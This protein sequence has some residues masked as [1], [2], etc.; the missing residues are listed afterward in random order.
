MQKYLPFIDIIFYRHFGH[1]HCNASILVKHGLFDEKHKCIC[2]AISYTCGYPVGVDTD[3]K[4]LLY[5]DVYLHDFPHI[6]LQF[7]TSVDH[8]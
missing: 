6:F 3:K 7:T 1:V 5:E 4:H 2:I 8:L